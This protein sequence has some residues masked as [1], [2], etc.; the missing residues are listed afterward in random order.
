MTSLP[1]RFGSPEQFAACRRLLEDA[2]YT[3]DALRAHYGLDALSSVARRAPAT[4]IEDRL[5]LLTQLFVYGLH[6]TRGQIES[7]L[8][9]G[10]LEALAALGLLVPSTHNQELWAGTVMLYPRRGHYFV[11]DRSRNIDGSPIERMGDIVFSALTDDTERFLDLLPAEPCESL[12][13]LGTGAGV[14]ALVGAGSA[15]H[16]WAVDITDRAARFAEFNRRLNA[17]PNVTVLQGDLYAPVHDL[18]F[19]RIVI[20]P[21]FVPA[22]HQT[23]IYQDAGLDGQDITRRAVSQLARHLNPGGRFYCLTVGVDAEDAPFEQTVR[24]WLGPDATPFDVAFLPRQIISLSFLARSVALKSGLGSVGAL[25]LEDTFKSL[26]IREFVYGAI[27]I[28]RHRSSRAGFTVRRQRSTVG[29]AALPWLL[30]WE[31][32]LASRGSE[33]LLD[34]RPVAPPTVEFVVTHRMVDGELSPIGYRMQTDHPLSTEARA[35]PWMGALIAR[36]DGRASAREHFASLK[37]AGAFPE[38]IG[39]ADF[40]RVLGQLVSGG[41]LWIPGFEPKL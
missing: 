29:E 41:F 19:D 13:D 15:R 8:P 9:P 22:L 26:R 16:V 11:S 10:S 12:L 40:A 18:Q 32:E 34:T 27:V 17:V 36:C 38:Q 30:H 2:S 39:P 5:E 35:A 37:E 28:Q 14:A 24:G 31:T 3:E 6:A 1:F 4:S 20:H 21:P 25:R 23:L 7:L 33:W